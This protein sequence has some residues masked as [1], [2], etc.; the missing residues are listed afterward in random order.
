MGVAPARP[1]DWA[2]T[3]GHL[4]LAWGA[5][6]GASCLAHKAEEGRQVVPRK[7]QGPGAEQ[8]G[9]SLQVPDPAWCQAVRPEELAVT[10]GAAWRLQGPQA[11]R[12]GV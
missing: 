3:Q 12:G 9:P 6:V 4:Y 2:V 1:K 5:M 8:S 7:G 10:L 11:P